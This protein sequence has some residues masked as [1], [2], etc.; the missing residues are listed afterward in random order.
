MLKRIF[1]NKKIL[2]TAGPVWVPIDKVRV[3]TN[4]FSGKL[5]FI[6]AN[7]AYTLGAD[8]TLLMGPGKILAPARKL[9]RF[10]VIKFRYFNELLELVKTHVGSKKYDV[11]IHSAAVSD[12]HP[13]FVKRGKIKSGEKELVI[14]LKPTIKIVDLVKKIDPNIFLVKF[15][16][17]VGLSQQ[18]LIDIAYKSMIQSNADLIV[19]NDFRTITRGYKNHI[20]FIINPQKLIKKITGKEKIA[21]ELL[22][23]ISLRLKEESIKVLK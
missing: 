4:I 19:A 20:A 13:I 2:I 10:K 12:Y 15:K 1:N 23:I 7:L 9:S 11:I 21:N 16:L 22:R 14:R 17:E 6:I 8:V 18:E 5:G 3:I